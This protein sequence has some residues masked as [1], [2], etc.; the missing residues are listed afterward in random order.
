MKAKI[1]IWILSAFLLPSVALNVLLVKANFSYMDE[2]YGNMAKQHMLNSRIRRNLEEFNIEEAKKLLD[3]EIEL[4]G[5]I[6]AVCL[7][8][9]CSERAKKAMVEATQH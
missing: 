5:V 4:S 1:T 9:N 2:V 7:Q 6:V 8:E 3:Q